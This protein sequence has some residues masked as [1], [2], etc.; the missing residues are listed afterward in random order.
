[1]AGMDDGC[2]SGVR[3]PSAFEWRARNGRIDLFPRET[4]RRSLAFAIGVGVGTNER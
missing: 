2:L 1:M 4:S 3:R